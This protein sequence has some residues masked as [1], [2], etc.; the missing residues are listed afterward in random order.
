M[1]KTAALTEIFGKKC[2]LSTGGVVQV[3]AAEGFEGKA[4]N[5]AEETQA[6]ELE[7]HGTSFLT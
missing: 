7:S 6:S 2:A 5:R 1:P 4:R 3:W